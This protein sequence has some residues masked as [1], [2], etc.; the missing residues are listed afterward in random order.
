MSI[1]GICVTFFLSH[2]ELTELTE[3]FFDASLFCDFRGFRVPLS[4][5]L[6]SVFIYGISVRLFFK[7]HTE[8]TELTE[9]FFDASLFCA[10]RAF[11]VPLSDPLNIRVHLWHLA[12]LIRDPPPLPL[13]RGIEGV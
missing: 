9:V 13:G 6:I 7:S 12:D 5:P 8:L 4:D 1:R 2:T 10:F 11:C 3:G